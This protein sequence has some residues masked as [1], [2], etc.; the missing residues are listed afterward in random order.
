MNETLNWDDLRLFLAV[1]RAGGLAGA[2]GVTGLSPPTLGRRMLG[3]ERRLGVALFRRHRE[4]YDLTADG[5]ALLERAELLEAQALAVER[6]R[7]GVDPGDTVRVAAGAWTSRLLAQNAAGLLQGPEALRL[8]IVTGA[9]L[10][11]LNRRQANLG[12]RSRRP[13]TAGLAA[14]RLGPVAFAVYGAGPYL[15][16][17]AEA[18]DTRRFSACDWILFA[19]G[20]GR[21]PSSEWLEA[22]LGRAARIRCSAAQPVLDAAASG[23]GLCVLPCFIG[24]RDQRLARATEPIPELQHD[25]WLVSQDDDRHIPPI[26]RM[27]ERLVRLFRAQRR[28]IAGAEPL[29]RK[30][31][32]AG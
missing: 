8:E 22:R 17:Q 29:R 3:L 23:A 21:A 6:W 12:I 30:A 19:P 24:D 14:R 4:G 27:A 5:R 28:L 1:A 20:E 2:A 13:E 16:R 18:F 31:A 32:A 25:Q 26:R 11:D 9:G 10:A 7:A 15:A